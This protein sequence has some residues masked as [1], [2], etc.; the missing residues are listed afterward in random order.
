MDMLNFEEH[1]LAD[2]EIISV[3]PDGEKVHVAY[4]DWQEK[5]CLLEFSGVVGYQSFSPEGRQLSHGMVE[6]DGPFVAF[7]CLTAEEDCLDGFKVF[8]FVEARQGA[9]VLRL[10][11]K[12]VSVVSSVEAR[13]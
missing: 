13:S 8:S 4:R 6:T 11:A 9:K 12:R 3:A 1:R 2:A 5:R 7:S 10:V